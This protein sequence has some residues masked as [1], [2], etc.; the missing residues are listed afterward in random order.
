SVQE[1]RVKVDLP[2][3]GYTWIDMDTKS[4]ESDLKCVDHSIEN[5]YYKVEIDP[6]SGGIKSFF[7]KELNKEFAGEYRGWKLGQLIHQEVDPAT[8]GYSKISPTPGRD[9]LN[10]KWNFSEVPDFGAWNTDVKFINRTCENIQVG[11]PVIDKGRVAISVSGT[12]KGVRRATALIWLD[13]RV[14]SLGIEW[15]LDKEHVREAEEIFVAFP[16]RLSG[17]NFRGDVNAV[18]F[19]PDDDQ[20]PG[21]VRDWFPVRD[22]MDV[23]DDEHGM[24]VV[25]IDAPLIQL[26]G[27]TTAKA[28]KKL[29]P[30]GPVIMSWALNN[31]WMVNF[32]ASQGGIIPLR[33]QLTTHKGKVDDA[34]AAKYASEIHHPA[35]ILRDYERSGSTMSKS[36]LSLQKSD[37]LNISAKEAEDG[38]GIILRVHS[39][40]RTNQEV[41]I[42]ISNF[43]FTQAEIVTSLENETNKKLHVSEGKISF[44]LL[45]SQYLSLKL[46]R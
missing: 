39:I 8:D 34:I 14:K 45:P 5:Q 17:V 22:W 9:S 7:D 42:D 15:E 31:H 10:A 18:P 24:T 33:Y 38:S 46:R 30:E 11:K 27:I 41:I 40:L 6:K 2:A 35:I 29:S 44:S 4:D 19:V 21:T 26:G 16:A 28:A 23:S 43:G 1:R 3:F 36:F 37:G 32:K 13:S 20:L 12:L 25:P